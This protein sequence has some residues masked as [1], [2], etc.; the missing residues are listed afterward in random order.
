LHI[1][2]KWARAHAPGNKVRKHS[3]S[4]IYFD[5]LFLESISVSLK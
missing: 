3:S 2:A 1:M 5:Q 4:V